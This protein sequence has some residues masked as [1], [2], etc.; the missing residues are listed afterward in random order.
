MELAPATR[1]GPV[2]RLARGAWGLVAAATVVSIVD[3]R[4]PARFRDTHILSEPSAWLLHG[5]ALLVF[6]LLVGSLAAARTE[7]LSRRAMALAIVIAVVVVALAAFIGALVT[8][9][10]W[11]FPLADLVWVFDV[12]MLGM[13]VV[14]FALAV[15]RGTPGCEIGV[16][17]ELRDHGDGPRGPI[18]GALGC[19]VGLGLI[20]RWE[21]SRRR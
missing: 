6:T 9:I 15:G 20:D 13:E 8:G 16:W 2:G 1:T 3:A 5:V 4:G 12:A 19:V 10:V 7:S 18:G 14:A 21:A 11:G 17:R